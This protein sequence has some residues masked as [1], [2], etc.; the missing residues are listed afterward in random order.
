LIATLAAEVDFWTGSGGN[1]A[2]DG[3]VIYLAIPLLLVAINAI[4]VQ[5]WDCSASANTP[6]LKLFRS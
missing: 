6:G 4:N 2:I 5:V 3:G 1:K